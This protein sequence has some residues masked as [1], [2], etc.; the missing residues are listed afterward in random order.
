MSG[1][2]DINIDINEI[3][4]LADLGAI[5]RKDPK[6]YNQM[7]SDTKIVLKDIFKVMEEAMGDE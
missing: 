2:I 5:K 1:N 3:Y 4:A 6:R 7:M